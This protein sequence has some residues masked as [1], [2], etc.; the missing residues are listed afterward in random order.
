MFPLIPSGCWLCLQTF[1]TDSSHYIKFIFGHFYFYIRLFCTAKLIIII[2]NNNNNNNNNKNAL[3]QL[4]FSGDIAIMPKAILLRPAYPSSFSTVHSFT[5]DYHHS[6]A[7]NHR[8]FD[9]VCISSIPLTLPLN[10]VKKIF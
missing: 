3:S 9:R 8:H 2:I 7:N 1:S 6:D 10:Q 4:A 5:I